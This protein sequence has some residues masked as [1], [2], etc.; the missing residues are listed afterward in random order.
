MTKAAP[1]LSLRIASWGRPKALS[2]AGAVRQGAATFLSPTTPRA[3]PNPSPWLAEGCLGAA[4]IG[5]GDRN[6]AT[7]WY[8]SPR[9]D[10]FH[11]GFSGFPFLDWCLRSSVSDFRFRHCPASGPVTQ[12]S[13]ASTAPCG[14][15][16]LLRLAPACLLRA[17]ARRPSRP[18][19]RD[20][21]SSPRF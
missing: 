19:G 10:V 20:P 3:A 16:P 8:H 2:D 4:R 12:A 5:G 14:F 6:V 11:A 21:E 9:H 17:A 1:A 15:A 18:R 7:P 13:S